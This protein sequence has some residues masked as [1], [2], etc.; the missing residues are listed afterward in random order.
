[1]KNYFYIV[2]ALLFFVFQ[3][4]SSFAQEYNFT[5]Y[6]TSN[7]L[8]SNKITSLVQDARGYLW[9][10][11]VDGLSRFDGNS[12]VNYDNFQGLSENAV[13][14]LK[15]DKEG[16]L[17]VFHPNKRVTKISSDYSF[18]ILDSSVSN[19]DFADKSTFEC[20]I[21]KN[22][23]IKILDKKKQPIFTVSH[24][25]GLVD[26]EINS[27][28]VDREN[29]LWIATKNNGILS[30][31]LQNFPFFKWQNGQL[32]NS[33]ELN[34]GEYLLTF[35]NNIVTLSFEDGKP[36]YTEMFT[37]ENRELNCALIQSDNLLFYG[38]NEGLFLYFK[39]TDHEFTFSEL[40]NKNVTYIE[41]T[42][43]GD[44]IIIADSRTYLYDV[45]T[46]EV[47]LLEGLEK[48]NAFAFQKIKNKVYLLG[49]GNIYKLKN[50]KFLPLLNKHEIAKSQNF[51]HISEAGINNLWLSSRN[52]GIFLF[53]PEDDRLE[54]FN[55]EKNIP[56][57]QTNSTLQ[58]GTNLWITTNEEIVWYDLEKENYSRFGNKY[59]DKKNFSPF[60]FRD[61][62]KLYFATDEG[63][64]QTFDS[65]SFV[66]TSN[67][68]NITDFMVQG[69]SVL[70]DTL[71]NVNHNSFPIQFN[72]QSIS[73]KEKTYYQTKLEG[74]DEEWS[75]S[76]LKVSRS[77]IILGPGSYTFRVRTVDPINEVVLNTDK[78][79]FKVLLPFW[80]TSYFIYIL[81]GVITLV[82]FTFYFFR[83]F[84]L[85]RRAEKLEKLVEE[86]TFVLSAQNQ[87]IEQF[88]YSLSHDLKNPI[89]NIKG[90]VEIM[91]DTE[92]ESQTEIKTLLMS[93]AQLLEDK[94]K[95]T[96]KTIQQMQANKTHVELLHFNNLVADTKRSLLILIKN[97]NVKFHTNFKVASIRYS[98]SILESIFYNLISNSIKYGSDKRR[99]T[100]QIS[101]YKEED[102]TVL[103]F[104]DNGIG[105]DLEKDLEKLFSIFER[106]DGAQGPGTG[107]GLYMVKQMVELNG[108]SISVESEVH[109]GTKFIIKLSSME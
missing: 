89:N 24:E 51:T 82:V 28:L 14:E 107:L 42:G 52:G 91:E 65:K 63:L 10:G 23:S 20:E 109:K 87:N 80:K 8:T 74:S 99:T 90:L 32:I 71:I 4:E 29:I 36:T 53:N 101:S 18:L 60:T 73:L 105:I 100:I 106:V 58:D 39:E 6:T 88:S 70:T 68:L 97:N 35:K 49:E 93:S 85:K 34:N 75:N 26:Y 59:L 19:F 96:L 62:K 7:G 5:N 76:T 108:G 98:P 31:P 13:S 11:S 54:N 50:N 72:Y 22:D 83:L 92:D 79:E 40:T 30:L 48:F 15:I 86:K 21:I 102:F 37:N 44:L 77:F 25:N 78:K 61:N 64:V 9:I 66:S 45:Y 27:A 69:K 3:S 16:N 57:K 1:M 94:I 81:F 84:T 47:K 2:F 12:F 17:L 55:Q 43:N 103:E 104:E 41:K 46:N 67:I 95:A 56:L 33:Y 38:T